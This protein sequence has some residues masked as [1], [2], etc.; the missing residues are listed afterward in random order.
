MSSIR[1]IK[2]RIKSVKSTAQITKAMQMVAASKMKRAQD[3]ASAAIPY[4]QGLYE[5]V[6]KIATV[7]GYSHPILRQ[8]EEV[9]KVGV[10]VIAPSRGFA[11]SLP[12]ALLLKTDEVIDELRL[13]YKDVEIRGIGV[14]KLGLKTLV[15]LNVE[16]DFQFAEFIESPTTTDLTSIYKVI[17]EKFMKGEYDEVHM[18]YT[19]FVNTAI[20]RP[21]TKKILP[22]SLEELVETAKAKQPKKE[23]LPAGKQ[24]NEEKKDGEEIDEVHNTDND[25]EFEPSVKVVLNKLLPEYFEMQIFAALL[26][27]IASEH[28]ARMVAMKQATDNAKEM[29]SDL[30]LVY[31]KTRQTAIT[32]EMLEIVGGTMA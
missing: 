27:S 13:K 14:H 10:L 30:T 26:E 12:A 20:Q 1:E 9:K 7:D 18:V 29:V 32:Q 19:H 28:S 31:N 16:M 11:G 22:L 23:D 6:N 5:I 25:F 8:V 4:A 2:R 17:L 24:G 15:K 3:R 21:T